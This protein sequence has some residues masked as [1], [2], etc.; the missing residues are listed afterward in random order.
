MN[1]PCIISYSRISTVK[2]LQGSGLAMQ[3][4]QAVL[5]NLSDKYN[6]PINEESFTD[7]GRSAYH[8][9]HLDGELGKIFGLIETG[10]IAEGSILCVY[11]LDRLS[12]QG[13]KK[14]QAQ[15][16]R[17][18]DT[19]SIY[20]ISDSKMYLY[21]EDNLADLVLAL[22]YASRANEESKTKSARTT[23]AAL[24]AINSYENDKRD[25]FSKAITAV[26]GSHPFYF[27]IT[28][29]YVKPHS[30]YFEVAQFIIHELIAGTNIRQ[31]VDKLNAT[32]K[33]HLNK[34]TDY[35]IRNFHKQ[36]ALTGNKTITL[37]GTT[38]VLEGY[39]PRVVSEEVYQRFLH[40]RNH[41]TTRTSSSGRVNL[42]TGIGIARCGSCGSAV[43]A[44]HVDGK[45]RLICISSKQR[46]N[47][48][49]GFYVM[50]HFLEAATLKLVADGIAQ[51]ASPIVENNSMSLIKAD[52]KK[53]ESQLA[54]L[55]EKSM[56]M[57]LPM[58]M[59]TKMNEIE[60]EIKELSKKLIISPI[61]VTPDIEALTN[62]WSHMSTALPPMEQK[63]ERKKLKELIKKSLTKIVLTK[64]AWSHYRFE[65]HLVNGNYRS[66]ECIEGK[67]TTPHFSETPS[68]DIGAHTIP[69][70]SSWGK[71]IRK[72]VNI[73]IEEVTDIL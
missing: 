62:Q 33:P 15:L 3:Q 30:Y 42:I 41:G 6:L 32:Y 21:N 58:V 71:N 48:C 43:G 50:A 40:T 55:V 64:V 47:D 51:A 31:L 17:I 28:N 53:K 29:G 52:I 14:A 39:Y 18:L 37:N 24:R 35:A 2:Q 20:T 44:S 25:G 8:G 65:F 46:R 59:L 12:R 67:L 68:F 73:V 1:Q 72:P 27:D 70:N 7:V 10:A 56:Q 45:T 22:V 9:K 38:H 61:T 13:I 69:A 57:D 60:S 16:L 19:V 36:D 5:A 66:V 34:W 54:M 11:N 23:N 63:D 4:E 26:C 49:K